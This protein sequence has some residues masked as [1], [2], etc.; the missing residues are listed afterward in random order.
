VRVPGEIRRTHT[1]ETV[2]V[3]E[4]PI[5][6]VGI[7]PPSKELEERISRGKVK[8]DLYEIK[9][10]IEEDIVIVL[11]TP[12]GVYALYNGEVGKIANTEGAHSIFVTSDGRILHGT[13]NGYVYETLGGKVINTNRK[14]EETVSGIVEIG[15]K[16][17][18]STGSWASGGLGQIL[19]TKNDQ[20]V[21]FF[22]PPIYC[23]TIAPR[24]IVADVLEQ[25][26]DL[27]TLI[28]KILDDVEAELES[29]R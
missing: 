27:K 1:N 7:V 10:K 17:Y 5:L 8:P 14:N 26:P 2:F 24:H 12:W 13:R 22:G 19:E 6:S 21:V 18:H 3:F 9:G 4:Y 29:L 11:G 20:G 16:L 23:M 28:T 25:A 15:N